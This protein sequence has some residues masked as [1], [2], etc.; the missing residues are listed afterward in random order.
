MRLMAVLWL[1]GLLFSLPA[2]V[3]DQDLRRHNFE[4]Q[5]FRMAQ[6]YQ[7]SNQHDLALRILKPLYDRNPGNV[8]YYQELLESYL[9]L[10]LFEEAAALIRQQ[11]AF[12]PT[13][14]RYDID[15]ANLLYHSD[16]KEEALRRW[17]RVIEQHPDN[18]ALYTLVANNMLSNGLFEE[19]VETYRQ[20]YRHFPDKHFLLKNVANFYRRRLHYR[21]AVQY[22]LEYVSKQP[23]DYQSVARQLLSIQVEE[24]QADSLIRLFRQEA[25]KYPDVPE[26]QLIAAQFYQRYQ[27]YPEA[28]R[29]YQSLEDRQ[30]QGKYLF[31]FAQAAQTDSVYDLALQAYRQIIDR[32]PDSPYVLAAYFGAAE[33]NLKMAQKNNDQTAARRAI[34]IIRSVREQYA[35]YPQMARLSLLEGDIYREFFFD[36]DRAITTY[37]D[38]ARRYGEEPEVQEQAYLKAGESY[39]IRG[40]LAK[41]AAMFARIS[42]DLKP[43][44]LFYLAKIAFYQHNYAEAENYL[45][46]VIQ[47]Q[48]LRGEQTNDALDLMALLNFRQTAPEALK[49]YAAADWL[50]FQQKKSQAI[51]RLRDALEHTPP[52]G[53]RVRI[54]LQAAELSAELDNLPE[55]LEYC[56]RILQDQ[57]LSLFADQA[58]FLMATIVDRRL[59]DPARAFRLY[60][61][62]LAEFPES[63]FVNTARERLKQLRTQNPDIVP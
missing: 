13:N 23:R 31:E 25:R 6:R 17:H 55:A 61:R 15:Y 47:M 50:I 22:Y 33:C 63:Q 30:S 14:P 62:L 46:Q 41:A 44:A 48:G 27:R 53:L 28:M 51:T 24:E 58:L 34:Q 26:I 56:N 40:D 59:N 35:T 5:Q 38:V 4:R 49:D 21:Q 1:T 54:L 42:A 39:I 7:S 9:K 43:K 12:D 32:Y 8:Q 45:N 11:R 20:A 19:A 3:G 18:L 16:Q 2:Q 29:I 37:L 57:E 60:D 52:P 10:S 36:I